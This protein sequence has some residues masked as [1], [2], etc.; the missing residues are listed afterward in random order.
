M[1]NV[2]F[3]YQFLCWFEVFL[4]SSFSG[5]NQ[6]HILTFSPYPLLC[7]ILFSVKEIQ[8]FGKI[9]HFCMYSLNLIDSIG[10]KL[11]WHMIIGV[12]YYLLRS[13]LKGWGGPILNIW[14]RSLWTVQKVRLSVQP[15]KNWKY[16]SFFFSGFKP[17]PFCSLV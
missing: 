16:S 13:K 9:Y 11:T 6:I 12:L 3:K 5:S 17:Y 14:C 7:P 8:Y 15:Y 1:V 2:I 4:D 10:L